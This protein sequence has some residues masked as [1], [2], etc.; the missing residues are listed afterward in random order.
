MMLASTSSMGH[1]HKWQHEPPEGKLQWAKSWD[2]R[3]G[4]EEDMAANAMYNSPEEIQQLRQLLKRDPGLVTSS[5]WPHLMEWCSTCTSSRMVRLVL[6]EEEA[7]VVEEE[8][9]AETEGKV[10]EE[11]KSCAD[12]CTQT[13]SRKQKRRG[14]RGSRMRRMLAFQLQLSVKK[15]LPLSR[16]LTTNSIAKENF[17]KIQEGTASPQLK[18]KRAKVKLE[19]KQEDEIIEHTVKEEKEEESGPGKEVLSSGS[20][21]FTLRNFPSVADP[22][23][24]QPLPRGPCLP[25]SPAV[26]PSPPFFTPPWIPFLHPQQFGQMPAAN[27]VVCGSCQM[28]GTVVPLWASQ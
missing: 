8:M 28:W 17:L 6:P 7:E 16:L 19:R 15:G 3:F 20:K 9:Y 24:T 14:G 2:E 10:G 23:S 21:Y 4:D 27:W 5:S 26:S 1:H 25:P 13:S 18:A 11:N 12:A 22:P